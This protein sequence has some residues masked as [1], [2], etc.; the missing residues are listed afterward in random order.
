[1]RVFFLEFPLSFR[2]L[3]VGWQAEFVKFQK[4]IKFSFE[5]LDERCIQM[6]ASKTC[7]GPVVFKISPWIL[8]NFL[9]FKLSFI[10][11]TVVIMQIIY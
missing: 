4:K 6:S 8:E 1:M 10:I 11:K 5:V 7:M 3:H 2:S 9:K